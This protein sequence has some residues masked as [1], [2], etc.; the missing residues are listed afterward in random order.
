MSF[1]D[2]GWAAPS[3]VPPQ[4]LISYATAAGTVA[5][6]G[7]GTNSPYA[8]ALIRH[9]KTPGLEVQMLVRKVQDE[10][11][12]LTDGM[13]MP[14]SYNSLGSEEIFLVTPEEKPSGLELASL[15]PSERKSVQ[16]SL[17]LIGWWEGPVDGEASDWL[18]DTVRSYQRSLGQ[19]ATGLLTPADMLALYRK[20]N[21]SQPREPLPDLGGMATFLRRLR[22]AQPEALR[23]AGMIA[24]PAFLVLSEDW[25]KDPKEAA[26]YYRD[27]AERG[28]TIAMT[29]LG[30]L[31]TRPTESADNQATGRTW[32]ERAADRGDPQ[33]S[34]RL[35]QLL[36]SGPAS[37]GGTGR[38]RAKELLKVA[39]ASPDTDGIALIQLRELDSVEVQ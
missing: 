27:A 6:D 33:A 7:D 24:D 39:A 20:A 9:L 34:L 16:R 1:S 32:L 13:Q 14:D 29:R 28:D 30:M 12:E 25:P 22:E 23:L 17:K 19:P 2:N 18:V 3:Q 26:I 15:E 37:S 11:K 21:F 31:L 35:A 5:Y 10:V 4:T 38:E 36:M 8:T